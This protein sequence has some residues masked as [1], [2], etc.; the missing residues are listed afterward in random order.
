[1][2]YA[3]FHV[4]WSPLKVY[5]LSRKGINNNTFFYNILWVLM[6]TIM[7]ITDYMR[8]FPFFNLKFT[9]SEFVAYSMREMLDK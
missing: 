8:V 3:T 5:S 9:M 2:L 1:M 4:E 7:Y 6:F